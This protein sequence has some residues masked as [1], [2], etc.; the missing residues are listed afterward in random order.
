MRVYSTGET[1]AV[2]DHVAGTSIDGVD[3]TGCEVTG[4]DVHSIS[5]HPNLKVLKDG[6]YKGCVSENVA[7]Q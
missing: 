1:P 6:T 7:K 5:P 3:V 4:V 2:G